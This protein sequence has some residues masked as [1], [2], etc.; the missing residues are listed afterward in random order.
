MNC[1]QHQ[2]LQ[3]TLDTITAMRIQEERH[4]HVSD[5]Y[6]LQL[7]KNDSAVNESCRSLMVDWCDNVAETCGYSPETVEIAL[8]CLD[9][10]LC[11]PCGQKVLHNRDR[12]QLA[13]MTAFYSAVKIHEQEAIDP[14]LL[15][16]LCQGIH[17]PKDIEKME[18]NMLNAL[19]WRVNPPTTRSFARMILDVVLPYDQYT[20]Y[21]QRIITDKTEEQLEEIANKNSFISYPNLY[22]AF[23][24][25]LNSIER[26]FYNNNKED[27][28][29]DDFC[30][31]NHK[32][33]GQIIQME[34]FR[35]VRQLQTMLYQKQSEVHDD[36]EESNVQ[37]YTPDYD[38]DVN[39]PHEKLFYT[40]QSR[41]TSP[42]SVRKTSV[43][44]AA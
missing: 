3:Q 13:V 1:D 30:F 17:T 6:L 42:Q 43:A 26:C 29:D 20:K 22:V 33:I 2:Q 7:P 36:E 27:A 4:Y 25:V 44:Q 31:R 10:Y 21:E 32:L 23:A 11:T 39:K 12:F 35:C 15:S 18:S 41:R 9:R 24:S 37:N 8:N 40:T 38:N 14:N 34:D 16:T 19:S 5:N 28:N